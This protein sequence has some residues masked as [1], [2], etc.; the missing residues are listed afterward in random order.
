MRDRLRFMLEDEFKFG[1]RL[2]NKRKAYTALLLLVVGLGAFNLQPFRD[3]RHELAVHPYGFLAIRC[4]LSV[5]SGFFFIGLLILQT[6]LRPPRGCTSPEIARLW[7]LCW[8]RGRRAR[9][10]IARLRRSGQ[11]TWGVPLRL[12]GREAKPRRRRRRRALSRHLSRRPQ[13][14][15]RATGTAAINKLYLSENDINAYSALDRREA[16]VD[17]A[18]Q[19]R[20]AFESANLSNRRMRDRINWGGGCLLF[21]ILLVLL[22]FVVYNWSMVG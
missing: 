11:M 6:S 10:R 20:E 2:D 15:S 1:D 8:T 18:N 4:L 5:A 19:L 9:L 13:P 22:A 16:L 12:Q 3:P 7:R 17:E 21:G 14:F